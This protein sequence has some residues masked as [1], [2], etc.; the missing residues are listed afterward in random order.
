M[1]GDSVPAPALAAEEQARGENLARRISEI[2]D[3]PGW[4][5]HHWQVAARDAFENAARHTE[6]PEEVPQ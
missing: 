6:Q 1:R 5:L 3:R 4:T 2:A